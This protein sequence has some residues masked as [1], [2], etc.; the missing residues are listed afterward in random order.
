MT[1]DGQGSLFPADR[2]G[3]ARVKRAVDQTI[4]VLRGM[5]AL[6]PGDDGL[7]AIA[8]TLAELVDAEAT[9][10]DG[11]RYTAGVLAGRLV[12]V[13]LEL[14][15]ERHDAGSDVGYDAELAA[16]VSAVR[17]ATRRDAPDDR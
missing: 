10:P 2:P 14:R 4:R 12:P 7:V 8:R 5:D 6:H 17:D 13:L 3:V 1:A 16:L 11:S 15:G 9:D